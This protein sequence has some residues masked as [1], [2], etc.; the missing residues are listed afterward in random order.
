MLYFDESD[1]IVDV[2]AIAE[3]LNTIIDGA[4]DDDDAIA[5]LLKHTPIV[6]G[7]GAHSIVNNDLRRWRHASH[8]SSSSLSLIDAVLRRLDADDDDDERS[9]IG[10]IGDKS[11]GVVDVELSIAVCLSRLSAAVLLARRLDV[12]KQQREQQ[13]TYLSMSARCSMIVVSIIQSHFKDRSTTTK[14]NSN[15]NNNDDESASIA[16]LARV[17]QHPLVSHSCFVFL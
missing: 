11:S 10:I 14:Q 7:S 3:K 17:L 5:T 9:D 6:D 12:K 16:I 4:D 1:T 15:A 13:K 8:S 2:K